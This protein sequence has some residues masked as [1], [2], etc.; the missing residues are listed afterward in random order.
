MTIGPAP[1]IRMLFMS[2]LFGM[3]LHHL[4]EA[5]EQITD[6]VRSRARFWMALE[7]ESRPV[8]PRQSLEGTVEEG[9]MRR[10]QVSAYR[11]GIDCKTVVLAGDHHLPGVEVLHRM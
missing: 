7:A 11:L 4:R 5:I 1:M 10:P 2:V 8:G 9:Y 3:L 6:V